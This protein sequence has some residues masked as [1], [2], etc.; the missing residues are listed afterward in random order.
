MS[1]V[2]KSGNSKRQNPQGADKLFYIPFTHLFRN[3]LKLKGTLIEV[4]DLLL[5]MYKNIYVYFYISKLFHKR[6]VP[7]C[8]GSEGI[9]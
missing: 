4:R 1:R 7:F 5:C 3:F 6:N 8:I 9:I 2:N